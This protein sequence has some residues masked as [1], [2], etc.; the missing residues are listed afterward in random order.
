MAK[1]TSK[2]VRFRAELKLNG[3]TATGFVVPP[4]IVER[5][6]AGKRVSVRASVGAYTYRTTVARMGGR[7]L[8]PVSA[9][10]REKAGIAA[11]DELD[12]E[13]EVDDSP[14]EVAMPPDLAQALGKNAKAKAF[15]DGLTSSQRQW[16]VTQVA[17][18]RKTETRQRRVEEAVA[19]LREGRK[20]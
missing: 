12:I 4:E 7:F 20:R 14:R 17:S 18:A 15:F 3:K 19:M 8:M 10:H 6:G 1:A 13:L 5:L 9:E 11:G 2:G 16:F